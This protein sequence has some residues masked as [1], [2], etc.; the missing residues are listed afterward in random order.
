MNITCV[1]GLAR[2]FQCV[3][4]FVFILIFANTTLKIHIHIIFFSL[5]FNIN[6]YLYRAFF[7]STLLYSYLYSSKI[8]E[9]NI[10][11]FICIRQERLISNIFICL[12]MGIILHTCC[13]TYMTSFQACISL[14]IHFFFSLVCTF[15][16]IHL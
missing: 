6:L 15:F 9:I 5:H 10:P 16:S 3:E 13:V 2:L 1:K 12:Q 8:L 14:R 4:M 11:I 7:L